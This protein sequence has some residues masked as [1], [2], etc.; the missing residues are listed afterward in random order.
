MG[1]IR[2]LLA[3]AVVVAH[4]GGDLMGIPLFGGNGYVA[5]SCFFIISG[6]YM[7]FVLNVKYPQGVADFYAARVIRLFP[8]YFLVLGVTVA[9]QATSVLTGKPLGAFSVLVA[10]PFS[11]W[12]YLWAA[13]AN[14]TFV[15]SEFLILYSKMSGVPVDHLT[16]L[17][18]IWSLGVEVFFYLMAPFVLRA[19]VA[20]VMAIFATALLLRLGIAWRFDFQWTMWTYYFGPANLAFFF[21]G[22]LAHRMHGSWRVARSTVAQ[23]ALWVGLTVLILFASRIFDIHSYTILYVLFALAVAPIFELSKNWK[24][25]RL[26]GELSYPVYLVHASILTVYAP[27]RHFIPEDSKIY[28]ITAGTLVLSMAAVSIEARWQAAFRSAV[29][30]RHALGSAAQ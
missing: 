25:D 9:I 16:V 6:F 12:Q 17:P 4:V 1:V 27:L 14:L 3:L 5:V 10:E 22:A 18:V 2:L 13:V 19:R 29:V 15:G 11:W 23:Y 30:S 26:V 7:S 21:A 8:L 28:W 20:V 24:W